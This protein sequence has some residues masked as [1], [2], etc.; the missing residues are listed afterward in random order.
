MPVLRGQT[1]LEEAQVETDVGHG[2]AFD[3]GQAQ[4]GRTILGI[5]GLLLSG[6]GVLKVEGAATAKQIEPL[7]H[8]CMLRTERSMPFRAFHFC[9]AESCQRPVKLRLQRTSSGTSSDKW[10]EN[11]L[12]EGLPKDVVAEPQRL[13]RWLQR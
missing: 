13:K 7:F 5:E 11:G 12:F 10:P 1:G 8:K 3:F 4:R 9:F 6:P 2:L